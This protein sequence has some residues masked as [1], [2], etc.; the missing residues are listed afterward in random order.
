MLF[1]W[2]N[3]LFD[4]GFQ[5][6]FA[7][8]LG[9]LYM[10]RLSGKGE[11]LI[12]EDFLTTFSAQIATLPILL[13]NFGTYSLWSIVVNVF[14]L[15][16]VPVLMIVGGFAAIA[17]FIFEPFSKFLLFICMPLLAYFEDT[18]NLFSGMKGNLV[19]QNV[20]WQFFVSYYLFL[21]S[22]L[23]FVKSKISKGFKT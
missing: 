20:P 6:S 1:L 8:T 4:I 16:T 14:V 3:F 5:L 19:F 15:W 21:I 2:P 17:S 18:V 9:I 11:N 23:I 12:T 7:S 13:A 10:P 22:I